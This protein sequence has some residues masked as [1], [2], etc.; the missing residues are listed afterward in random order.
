MLQ[1]DLRK[2][3]LGL[4]SQHLA[5]LPFLTVAC[6]TNSASLFNFAF[7]RVFSLIGRL[8]RTVWQLIRI[9]SYFSLLFDPAL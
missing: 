1:F 9:F 6:F 8:H 2:S 4:H 3:A 7:Q 5:I